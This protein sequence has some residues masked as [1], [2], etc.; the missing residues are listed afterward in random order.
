MGCSSSFLHDEDA[1]TVGRCGPIEERTVNSARLLALWSRTSSC[2]S[3]GY[4]PL[5]EEVQGGW[6]VVLSPRDDDVMGT[7]VSCPRCGGTITPYLEYEEMRE[8]E[9][10][11]GNNNDAGYSSS[12]WSRDLDLDVSGVTND[13]D[14]LPDD[15]IAFDVPPQL[16]TGI[17]D[18]RAPTTM[19]A[20]DRPTASSSSGFVPYLS[21]RRLRSALEDLILEYG[22]GILVRDRLRAVDPAVFFNLWWYSARF[23]LPLPVTSSSL[24][25]DLYSAATKS[26]NG[27]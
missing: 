25:F 9:M 7:T 27:A 6:D 23:S 20:E 13:D 1:T 11:L 19:S 16:R 26:E 12:A 15:D 24:L 10:S 22:E 18:G 8:E 3:C 14:D 5:D 4:V 2:A 21:P 17:G